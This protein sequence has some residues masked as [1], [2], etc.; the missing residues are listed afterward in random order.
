M[1][2]LRSTL[3]AMAAAASLMAGGSQAQQFA[4]A[5]QDGL[6]GIFDEV[7]AGT[8]FSVQPGYDS[9]F[10]LR[11]ELLF[12]PFVPPFETYLANTLLRPRLHLG[13]NLA[14]DEDE[15]VSQ[16]YAGFT[17]NFPVFDPF[18]IEATRNDS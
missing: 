5:S 14:T 17:W 6:F 3:W 11:G 16:V 15:G 9:H 10:I 7:R 1:R 18:F 12:R 2:R 13:G 4:G 8:S